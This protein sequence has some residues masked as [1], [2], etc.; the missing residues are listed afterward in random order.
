M[1]DRELTVQFVLR[2][3]ENI[4]HNAATEEASRSFDFYVWWQSGGF[5]RASA[6]IWAATCACREGRYS[7]IMYV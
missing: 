5:I 2:G 6:N 1:F 7:E 3:V 4:F